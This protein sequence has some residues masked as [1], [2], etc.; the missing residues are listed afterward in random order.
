MPNLVDDD[1]LSTANALS[2]SLW[3]TMLAIG[4]GLGGIVTAAVGR[5][6]AIAIDAASFAAS[7]ALIVR[8]RRPLSVATPAEHLAMREA[9]VETV[10]YARRDHRVL[11]LLAVKGGWALAGGVLVVLPIL[12]DDV[13]DAGDL[14]I[15]LLLA[16]RGVGALI[17][18]FLGRSLVGPQDRRLFLVIGLWLATFGVGYALVGLAPGLGFALGAVCLAHIGGGGQW[19]LSSYGLQRIVPDRIRGRI[20]AFDFMLVTLTFGV[21][22]LITGGL[23]DAFGPQP[24]AVGLGV[25]GVVWAAI[26][27][28]LTTDVRRATMLEGC[29]GPPASDYLTAPEA[30]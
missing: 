13:F 1:D 12:A 22:S 26:W 21:S 29:G 17:G 18:P 16:A 3:G 27:T 24:T 2:G 5:D 25:V 15:G 28:W 4:A 20:F 14:G 23:V 30:V 8:I 6:A 7:A 10:R 19:M 11:A 9:T